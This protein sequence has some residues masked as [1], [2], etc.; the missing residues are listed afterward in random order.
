MGCSSSTVVRYQPLKQRDDDAGDVQDIL[1]AERQPISAIHPTSH[2]V[3]DISTS[4]LE[5][6]QEFAPPQIGATDHRA[7]SDVEDI[8]Q[9]IELTDRSR[10]LRYALLAQHDLENQTSITGR[11]LKAQIVWTSEFKYDDGALSKHQ[12]EERLEK[13]VKNS[14]SQDHDGTK[15]LETL[16]HLEASEFVLGF[17]SHEVLD[18]NGCVSH[19]HPSIVISSEQGERRLEPLSRHLLWPEPEVGGLLKPLPEKLIVP[20][21]L[22]KEETEKEKIEEN[23][24]EPSCCRACVQTMA[25]WFTAEANPAA[26][27]A[28]RSMR[29]AS[30]RDH[31]LG[32]VYDQ[33]TTTWDVKILTGQTAMFWFE[34][35]CLDCVAWYADV[36]LDIKQLVLFARTAKMQYL[37]FNLAGM[38]AP[39]ILSMHETVEWFNRPATPALDSLRHTANMSL[40]VLMGAMLGGIAL[41]LQMLLLTLWSAKHRT[42]HPL[43]AGT[44]HAE[45]AESATSA[46]VQA[47][48]LVCSIAEVDGF[49]EVGA[50]DLL[51]LASSIAFSVFMLAFGFACR[52]KGTTRVLGHPGK[53]D[54]GGLLVVLICVRFMEV[55]S[56]ILAI[57]MF[58]VSARSHHF[59]VGGPM[60]VTILAMVSCVVFPHGTWPDVLAA[61][62]AHPGQL[63][64]A[65]SR[66]PL[67]GSLLLNGLSSG[68]V[69]LSQALVRSPAFTDPHA[70]ARFNQDSL[71]AM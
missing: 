8:S 35:L 3:Q 16:I 39:V 50:S 60:L 9:Q 10:S 27:A 5:C 49:D 37:L 54:W 4:A 65:K 70:K 44:K 13:K 19:Y 6:E 51:W 42:R 33:T 18:D 53:L 29:G 20:D 71:I 67:R 56:T 41:Q 12:V 30:Q 25:E 28:F 48:F 26:I 64:E 32:V 22:L 63:L 52:D 11:Y 21:G 47:N 69:V 61:V 68:A 23:S 43:L 57:N 17:S 40:N 58:H 38:A 14:S 31:L 46:L 59:R 7:R 55:G 66:L 36:L 45:V 34:L 62:I 15:I 2:E 24:Q 1:P